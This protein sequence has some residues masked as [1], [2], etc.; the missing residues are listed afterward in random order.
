MVDPTCCAQSCLSDQS[1]EAQNRYWD[2]TGW[3]CWQ[4]MDAGRTEIQ[5]GSKTVLAIGGV[6]E[7]VDQITGQ[8]RTLK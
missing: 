4:V 3:A 1:Q 2:R 7:A 5:P 8:L 6:D